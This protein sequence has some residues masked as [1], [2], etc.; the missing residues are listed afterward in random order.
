MSW[1][2]QPVTLTVV[3]SGP[4]QGHRIALPVGTHTIGRAPAGGIVI[5]DETLSREHA[6]LHHDGTRVT[7]VD[8]G[9]RNGT[10]V[11][12]YRTVGAHQLR[13]GDLV[14]LGAVDLR[15]EAPRRNG[16]E[17]TRRSPVAMMLV[18]G[19]VA[20]FLGLAVDAAFDFLR[21]D[22]SN[23][24]GIGMVATLTFAS[25]LIPIIQQAGSG[26]GGREAPAPR[27]RHRART[28]VAVLVVLAVCTGGAGGAA[29]V[30]Q[31]AGGWVTGHEDGPDVLVEE[32]SATAGPLTLTVHAVL[33]TTHFTRVEITGANDGDESMRLPVFENCFLTA[34]SGLTLTAGA[35]RSD[36][37]EAIP[38]HGAVRGFL[39]FGR[40]LPPDTT[41]VSLA[42]TTV[43]VQGFGGPDSITVP[44]IRLRWPADQRE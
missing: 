27:P 22:W 1:S 8:L 9:S 7:V 44:R 15:F 33:D 19:V 32:V 13:D 36:W 24:F 6:R 25:A 43:F 35:F 16:P 18:F 42:F 28:A 34:A 2:A 4:W 12:G 30:V 41:V 31:Y 17:R 38:P 29:W 20:T 14:Q 5:A 23:P 3:S 40:R 26:P 11:N 37:P 39:T 21:K 10:R